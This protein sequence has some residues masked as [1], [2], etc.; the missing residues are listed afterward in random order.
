VITDIGKAKANQEKLFLLA[1]QKRPSLL[2]NGNDKK[3]KKKLV[4]ADLNVVNLCRS[5]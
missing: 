4:C 3:L 1:L 5:S 2:G